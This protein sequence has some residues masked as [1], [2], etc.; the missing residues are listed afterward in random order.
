MTSAEV[1]CLCWPTGPLLWLTEK[2]ERIQI[3]GEC[4][5]LKDKRAA[6]LDRTAHHATVVHDLPAR[7]QCV[8]Y[9]AHDGLSST[10]SFD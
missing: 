7:L 10:I 3:A 1:G 5:L 9:S 6:M 2:R 4:Y 8:A